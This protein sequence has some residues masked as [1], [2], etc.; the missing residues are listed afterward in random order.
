MAEEN[1][2]EELDLEVEVSEPNDEST[3]AGIKFFKKP[4]Q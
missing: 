2:Q 3:D 1:V 4:N